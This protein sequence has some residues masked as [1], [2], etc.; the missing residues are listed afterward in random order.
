MLAQAQPQ[1]TGPGQGR[2]ARVDKVAKIHTKAAH[3]G[4]SLPA[5]RR[6]VSLIC[7]LTAALVIGLAG[8]G[9]AEA[10]SV[11]PDVT[12]SLTQADCSFSGQT[13]NLHYGFY[14]ADGR[15]YYVSVRLWLYNFS[16]GQWSHF[17]WSQ[18]ASVSPSQ[19]LNLHF[20]PVSHGVYYLL[21]EW[22]QY[23]GNGW[24]QSIYDKMD[25]VFNWL[26]NGFSQNTDSHCAL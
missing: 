16:T 9:T 2:F 18:P 10:V 5:M 20:G 17:L 26:P 4:V 12:L 8:T 7:A 24:S 25:Q 6:A 14:P 19:N 22:K 3:A 11:G 23:Q 21:T 15:S 1:R 13:I